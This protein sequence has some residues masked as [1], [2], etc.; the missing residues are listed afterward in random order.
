M[1]TMDG[2]IDPKSTSEA[3]EEVIVP[4]P[5]GRLARLRSA[6]TLASEGAYADAQ[7]LLGAPP[8]DEFGEVEQSLGSFISELGIA[9]DQS[10]AALDE[11]KASRRTLQQRLATIE[12]QRAAIRELSAPIIDIWE[13]VLA[14]PLTG[15]LDSAR[16]Q[17]LTERL[18]DRIGRVSVAWVILD[19]TGIDFVDTS[20]AGHL[21]KLAGAVRLMGAQCLLTGIGPR[22][23]QTFVSLGVELE[24]LRSMA[25][26]R[27]GLKY[28]LAHQVSPRQ[29]RP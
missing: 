26:L 17:E 21:I 22:V 5:A 7:R 3:D 16:A 18:L 23:A 27:E 10:N 4:V 1:A 11:I 20:I 6:V 2:G 29:G 28:C 13:G 19:L 12:Q 15:L 25:N 8:H 9:I 14:I 24:G